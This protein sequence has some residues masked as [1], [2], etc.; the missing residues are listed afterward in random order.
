M[1]IASECTEGLGSSE[2]RHAQTLLKPLGHKGFLERMQ[3]MPLADPDPWQTQ[4]L[5]R[6]L[7]VGKV[8]LFSEGLSG[9]DRE[10]TRVSIL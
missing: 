8:S 3:Q 10:L 1:V 4:M 5:L 7:E 2:F 9:A 6:T